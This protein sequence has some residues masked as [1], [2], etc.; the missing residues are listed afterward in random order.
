M[1][2]PTQS[3]GEFDRDVRAAIRWLQVG[4]AAQCVGDRCWSFFLPL[5]FADIYGGGIAAISAFG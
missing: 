5:L 4:Y 2:N 3:G 1:E